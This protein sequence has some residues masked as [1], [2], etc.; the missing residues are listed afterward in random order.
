MIS[1]TVLAVEAMELVKND[2]LG[3]RASRPHKIWHNR[4]YL[5][6]FDEAGTVQ[7]L[8]FRLVD[9]VPATMVAA[10]KTELKLSGGEAAH[11]P[12]CAQL[13]RRIERYA[14]Q[15]HGACWLKDARVA[16]WSG[17]RCCIMTVSGT[18]FWP[19]SSCPITCMR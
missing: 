16:R 9:A 7:F 19:G 17:M 14:D 3:A 6:H 2:N 12:R 13:C 10:W 11:D 8:A 4:G 18:G 15:G 5:P 1:R